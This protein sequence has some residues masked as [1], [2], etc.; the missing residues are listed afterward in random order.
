MKNG[1]VWVLGNSVGLAYLAKCFAGMALHN[2]CDGYHVHMA[3]PVVQTLD[4]GSVELSI[5]NRDFG[6]ASYRKF[7]QMTTTFPR[8]PAYKTNCSGN[9]FRLH[10]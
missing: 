2:G 7:L 6:G 5:R 3:W 9:A 4:K 10:P 8:R 1:S